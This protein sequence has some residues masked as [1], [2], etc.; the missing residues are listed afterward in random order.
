MKRIPLGIEV[1]RAPISTALAFV[2]SPIVPAFSIA[3]FSVLRNVESGN[4]LEYLLAGTLMF[5]AWSFGLTILLAL[6]LYLLLLKLGLVRWWSAAL[7]GFLVG[8]VAVG[9]L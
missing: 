9:F 1:R 4:D 5:Y 6:P 7:T 2:V 8:E 3:I